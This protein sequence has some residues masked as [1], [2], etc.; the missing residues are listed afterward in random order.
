M[1]TETR[2]VMRMC[3]TSASTPRRCTAISNADQLGEVAVE[4]PRRVEH[5]VE[6]HPSAEQ[7]R[8]RAQA[9]GGNHGSRYQRHPAPVRAQVAEHAQEQ[10]ALVDAARTHAAVLVGIAQP[11]ARAMPL[12]LRF[13][14]LRPLALLQGRHRA[15]ERLEPLRLAVGE[16]QQQAVQVGAGGRGGSRRGGGIA[17]AARGEASDGRAVRAARDREPVLQR[18]RRVPPR[19]SPMTRPACRRRR[20]WS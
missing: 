7:R 13:D 9:G 4:A 10:A 1:L 11:A 14:R 6:Q 16:A 17:R 3:S 2:A 12:P 19:R 20:G 15:G 5:V 8:H 18:R